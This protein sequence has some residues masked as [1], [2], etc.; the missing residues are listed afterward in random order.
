MPRPDIRSKSHPRRRSI[1]TSHGRTFT[2]PRTDITPQTSGVRSKLCVLRG[3]GD[4][5][6][7]LSQR[8]THSVLDRWFPDEDTGYDAAHDYDAYL[9]L[10]ADYQESE[11]T[12]LYLYGLVIRPVTEHRGRFSRIGYF[13]SVD[14]MPGILLDAGKDKALLDDSLYLDYDSEKG[15]TIE[16]V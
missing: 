5:T 1:W 9:L 13:S 8:H 11:N 16:I 7:E 4:R 10:V 14:I 2:D 3:Y 15:F 12:E 6:I